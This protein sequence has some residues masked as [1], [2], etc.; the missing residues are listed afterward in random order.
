MTRKECA[1]LDSDGGL[2]FGLVKKQHTTMSRRS[3]HKRTCVRTPRYQDGAVNDATGATN[4]NVFT[5]N[6]LFVQVKRSGLNIRV[7]YLT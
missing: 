3:A 4:V 2:F 6:R 1:M 5:L 7:A